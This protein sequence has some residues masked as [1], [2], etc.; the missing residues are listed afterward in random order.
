[1]VIIPHSLEF[2][3][4]WIQICLLKAKE[5]SL[6]FPPLLFFLYKGYILLQKKEETPIQTSNIHCKYHPHMNCR[7]ET[8]FCGDP[9]PYSIG[10]T[11]LIGVALMGLISNSWGKR[12]YTL[13]QQ[14]CIPNAVAK[15]DGWLNYHMGTN[16]A[17]VWQNHSNVFILV[18][19]LKCYIH[20][21][22]I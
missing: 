11:G 3:G 21:S 18:F 4:L 22:L 15:P 5:L 2:L 8:Q 20:W 19:I 16:H 7:R 9:A 10:F 1:M 17:D 6:L 13:Y 14:T 12:S